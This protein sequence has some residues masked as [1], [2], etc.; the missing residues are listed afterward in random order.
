MRLEIES[1]NAGLRHFFDGSCFIHSWGDVGALG[2]GL[3][4]RQGASRLALCHL[5][6]LHY[7]TRIRGLGHYSDRTVS[8]FLNRESTS[9]GICSKSRTVGNVRI[10]D[11]LGLNVP[12]SP[13]SSEV[14]T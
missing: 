5:M 8:A 1:P 13:L 10:G 2:G 4:R 3:E 9:E 7:Y 11:G 12:E 6:A 14:N